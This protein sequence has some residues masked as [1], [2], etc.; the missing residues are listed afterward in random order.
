[1]T[2][3][4]FVR[5]LEALGSKD[6]ELG[7]KHEGDY[8]M[9]RRQAQSIADLTKAVRYLT[10]RNLNGHHIYIRPGAGSPCVLLDD[11]TVKRLIQME[12]DGLRC[13][14]VVQTS[15]FNYQ[16]WLRFDVASLDPAL[17]TCLG[18]V[19][20][21]RYN[22]DLASKDFR[23]FGRAAGFTNV[24]PI[25][26]RC[27]GL[28]P[29]TRLEE[30]TGEVTPNSAELLA[31]AKKLL[32]TK[33][34]ERDERLKAMLSR[35]TLADQSLVGTEFAQAVAFVFD[36]FGVA[37]DP[38]RADAAA[39]RHLLL[40][41]YSADVIEGAMLSSADIQGRRPKTFED[42]VQRTVQWGCGSRARL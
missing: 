25:H 7:I 14:C 10:Y 9:E 39:V 4:V 29:F 5:Q 6:F 32:D 41:G 16:A 15:D 30:A 1:M 24:K 38:S 12:D 31:V 42:Y 21:T 11:L 3:R 27:D 22:A 17:A 40:K 34:A 35:T 26:Q 28:Y 18:E 20:A 36:Q 8:T 37:T 19:L 2:E 33:K 13:A 23:H